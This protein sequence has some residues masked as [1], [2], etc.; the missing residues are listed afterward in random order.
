MNLVGGVIF[1]FQVSFVDALFDKGLEDTF[2]ITGGKRS[3]FL[4]LRADG[5]NPYFRGGEGRGGGKQ[6]CHR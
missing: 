4:A 6:G 2:G 1:E 3:L 5:F